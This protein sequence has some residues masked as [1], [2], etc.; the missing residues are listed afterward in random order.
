MVLVTIT[1]ANAA[2]NS[3]GSGERMSFFLFY[4]HWFIKPVCSS[5]GLSSRLWSYILCLFRN[6]GEIRSPISSYSFRLTFQSN[7]HCWICHR[8]LL[9]S[10]WRYRIV[11]CLLRT[12]ECSN[13]TSICD[14][15]AEITSTLSSSFQRIKVFCRPLESPVLL[16]SHPFSCAL[17]P[18]S[19]YDTHVVSNRSS[20]LGSV[21]TFLD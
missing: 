18:V 1:T 7:N 3:W 15:S 16:V 12:R 19:L 10:R 9:P 8:R 14:I 5:I 4:G 21:S 6:L 13:W 2:G 20:L 17:Q 11:C